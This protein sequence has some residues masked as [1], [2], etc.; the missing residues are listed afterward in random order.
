MAPEAAKLGGSE[1]RGRGCLR[2][3]RGGCVGWVRSRDLLQQPPARTHAR[4]RRGES[5]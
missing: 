5:K 1:A 3:G 4:E 2:L